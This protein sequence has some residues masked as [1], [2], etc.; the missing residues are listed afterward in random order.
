M[1]SDRYHI[2]TELVTV[3]SSRDYSL[4]ECARPT[5]KQNSYSVDCC[6]AGVSLVLPAI[7]FC[8]ILNIYVSL[9]ICIYYQLIQL[10]QNMCKANKTSLS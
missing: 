8:F 9:L 6:Q 3:Q 7:L 1:L 4:M 10:I 5:Q 2:A